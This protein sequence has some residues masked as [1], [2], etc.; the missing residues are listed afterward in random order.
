MLYLEMMETKLKIQ[1]Q[2]VLY[3]NFYFLLDNHSMYIIFF[4]NY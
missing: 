1:I 2:V 4:D 3:W